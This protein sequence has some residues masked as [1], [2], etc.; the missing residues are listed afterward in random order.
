MSSEESEFGLGS[1]G[2][3]KVDFGDGE[4]EIGVGDMSD[5]DTELPD[6]PYVPNIRETVVTPPPPSPPPSPS[7]SVPP[8]KMTVKDIKL[9][10]KNKGLAISGTKG[11]LLDR[12]NHET[13]SKKKKGRPMLLAKP[14]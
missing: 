1:W 7:P 9:K 4:E 3:V 5:S 13:S 6:L 14:T 2:Q 8:P 11:K 10:L 12:L